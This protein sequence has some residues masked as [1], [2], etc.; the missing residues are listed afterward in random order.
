VGGGGG[1][2]GGGTAPAYVLDADGDFVWWYRINADVTNARMSYDGKWMWI[3]AANVPETQGANG[4]R[5]SMDGLIDQDLS[6]EFEGQNHQFSVLPDETVAFF[7][8]G[9]NGCDDIK[10]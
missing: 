6:D 10:E 3:S 5:V 8:Y 9:D 4:H 7:A 1:G 2:G